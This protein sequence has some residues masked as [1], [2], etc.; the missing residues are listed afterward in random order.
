M[1]G[2]SKALPAR[3]PA[4]L[5]S[6]LATTNV[7]WIFVVLVALV[8]FFTAVQPNFANP[9]NIRSIAADNAALLVL[10]VGM[11]F[12]IVSAGIDLSI[13]S[14]LIFSGVVAAKVMLA[15]GGDPRDPSAGAA[16]AGWGVIGLGILAGLLAGLAW[17]VINGLLVAKARVPPLIATLGTL[18]MALG[19]SY[20]LTGGTDVRGIPRQLA[21]TLGF[22]LVLNSVPWL[23]VIAAGVAVVLG[24]VLA[25][26]RFGRYTY[27]I[28]S[29]PE[30]ARRVGI[31]VDRHLI[32]VYALMGLLSGLAGVMSLA[33]FS[34]TT[35]SG[36]SA[37]N[38]AAIA[39]V[40]LGGTSLFGGSGRVTGTVIGVLIPAVLQSGFV[41]IG[42]NPYWQN[43]AVGAVLV[44]AVYLD[45]VRRR[46]RERA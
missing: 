28:G 43:V 3:P 6:R 23:V 44:A 22:G 42:V 34:T 15:V 16:D 20:L 2:T 26:T 30:A 12:V 8:L 29:N 7:L 1:S 33:H 11:T 40:V 39:A 46:A 27:A 36:H 10:A 19:A 17:G 45:Q 38:L 5:A 18:G 4:T 41:T 21:G 31:R 35:I 13:G 25:Y 14:V 37:D 24:L 32:K 9:L